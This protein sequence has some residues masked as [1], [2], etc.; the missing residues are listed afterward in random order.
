VVPRQDLSEEQRRQRNRSSARG[1][2][3]DPS[4]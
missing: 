4:S 3:P 1:S 2:A